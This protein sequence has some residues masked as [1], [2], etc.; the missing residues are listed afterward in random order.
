MYK[1]KLF[2][3]YRSLG[4]AQQQR[5]GRFLSSPYHNPREDVLALYDYIHNHATKTDRQSLRKETVYAALF[6]GPYK[7][8]K[9]DHLMSMLLQ[10]I[11]RFLLVERIEQEPLESQIKLNRSYLE[12]GLD[13]HFRQSWRKAEALREESP[14]RD[15]NYY[16]YGYYLEYQRYEQSTSERR[17]QAKNLLKLSQSFDIYFLAERFKQACLMLA[18]EAVYKVAYDRSLVKLLEQYVL[19]NTQLLA[20]DSP[21]SLYFYC[22]QSLLPPYPEASFQAFKKALLGPAQL[23]LPKAE[24][25]DLYLLAI[26]YC[27]R[28]SNSG[29]KHYLKELLYFYKSGLQEGI[30]IQNGR[31]PTSSFKN[32]VKAALKS[33]E[34]AWA[35]EF[36]EQYPPYLDP[37][38]RAA[39][40]HY[41]QG[42]YYYYL[43]Q[44]E[45]AMLALQEI[46]FGDIFM[47]LSARLLLLKMY[48]ELG[49]LEALEA[50]I[51]SMKI[52]LQR[53]DQLGYHREN[54]KNILYFCR[55]LLQLAPY[56]KIAEKKKLEADIQSRQPLTEKDW[57]LEQLAKK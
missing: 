37:K 23:A 55:R 49:E 16:R 57:L 12:L 46:E 53:K 44:Y 2:A 14:L 17:H 42:E 51:N 4:T 15:S 36:I 18:H 21:L 30:L 32:M 48:Y 33:K 7:V 28:R 52:Y 43:G 35:K 13:K 34:F 8:A 50:Q 25:R 29:Q 26:N 24:L 27:I 20:Q 45:Q 3:L 5:L 9:M 54:Y 40:L 10:L 56:P 47:N 22:Y 6:E 1:S 41:A 11:E 19:Q 38:H 39:Y 31:L